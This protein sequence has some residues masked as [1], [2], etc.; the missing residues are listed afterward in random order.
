MQPVQ[1]WEKVWTLPDNAPP[2]STLR[3]YKWVKTDM[4]QVRVKPKQAY[5]GTHV[6]VALQ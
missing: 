2:N 1:C 5:K 4:I 3:V 6:S